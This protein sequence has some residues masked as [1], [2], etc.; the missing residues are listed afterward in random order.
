MYVDAKNI[1]N[2]KHRLLPLFLKTKKI[3]QV[4]QRTQKSQ[5]KHRK[6]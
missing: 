2:T 5:N 6:L 3:C 4:L 1:K